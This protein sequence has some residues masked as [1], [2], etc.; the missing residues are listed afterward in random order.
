MRKVTLISI[1][2]LVLFSL[3]ACKGLKSALSGS[4]ADNSDEFLVQK[5]NPLVLPPDF[6]DLPIPYVEK[7]EEILSQDN[8]DIKKLLGVYQKK[9]TTETGTSKKIKSLEKE[10]LDKI[11]KN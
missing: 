10:I 3:S 8:T 4:K 7:D 5:K 9:A 6:N 1:L 11:K 2:F